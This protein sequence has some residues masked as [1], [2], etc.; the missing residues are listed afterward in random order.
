MDQVIVGEGRRAPA[1]EP[2]PAGQARPLTGV[3]ADARRVAAQRFQILQPHLEDGL[4]LTEAARRG[5]VSERTAR[6]WLAAYRRGELSALAPQTRKDSG[7]RRMPDQLQKLI[8][9]L[10]LRSPPLSAATVHRQI[11]QLAPEHGWPTPSYRTVCEI[12]AA[13]DP[14]LKCLAHEGS[15]RYA[16]TFELIARREVSEPNA[17]WQADHTPLDFYILTE[18]GTPARPW[19]TLILDEYSRAIAAYGLNL[20]APNAATTAVTLRRAIW[21]KSDPGWQVCGIP[22]VFYTDHGSDFTSAHLEQ[23]AADLKMRL[24]FSLPGQP[25]GRGKIERLFATVH[26]MC[27]SALPGYAPANLPQRPEQGRLSLTQLDEALHHWIVNDYHERVHPEIRQRP[28][29]R[30]AAGGFLPHMPDSLEQLDLLLLTVA[31]PRKVHPDGIHA[32]GLRYLDPTLAAFIGESVVIR[33]DPHDLA[34]LRVFHRDVFIC[35]AICPDLAGV[36]VSLREIIAARRAH[37]RQLKQELTDHASLVDQLLAHR[38]GLPA[39]L[40]QAPPDPP[41]RRRLKIYSEE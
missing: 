9:A 39:P 4:P 6:R 15:K 30:W 25:R 17:S 32:F 22:A 13:L 31:K 11:Q 34:E 28:A 14:A 10:A 40:D 16:D 21:R 7:A 8:E 36:T 29:D 20:E 18:N 3:P 38:T 5:K 33:Y 1:S 24:V 35:R 2:G 37:R 19:L 27:L 12:I 41:A 23:V 26:Q